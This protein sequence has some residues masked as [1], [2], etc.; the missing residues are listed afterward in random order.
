MFYCFSQNLTK[1]YFNLMLNIM[2][3]TLFKGKTMTCDMSE[4]KI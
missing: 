1:E 3:F 2:G 4:S